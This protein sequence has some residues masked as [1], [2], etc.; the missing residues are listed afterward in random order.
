M[1]IQ[2][3]IILRPILEVINH[4][5]KIILDKQDIDYPEDLNKY[6]ID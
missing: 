4:N 2:S 3:C 6:I 1:I 5:Y